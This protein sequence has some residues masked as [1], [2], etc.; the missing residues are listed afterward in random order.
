MNSVNRVQKDDLD[1]HFFMSACFIHF[2]LMGL[3]KGLPSCSLAP[4]KIIDLSHKIKIHNSVSVACSPEINQLLLRSLVANDTE[5][6]QLFVCWISLHAFCRLLIFLLF[7]FFF[8]INFFKTLLQECHKYQICG[9][10]IRPGVLLGL[11]WVKIISKEY[12]QTKV[13]TSYTQS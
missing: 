2:A 8:K 10:Q 6:V 11:V 9:I 3:S 12:Q 1:L 5:C 4:L 13:V 7:F